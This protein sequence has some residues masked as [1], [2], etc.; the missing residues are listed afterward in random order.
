[1]LEPAMR[2]KP[3]MLDSGH[4]QPRDRGRTV[5]RTRPRAKLAVT[6]CRDQAYSPKPKV[7]SPKS[8]QWFL[9]L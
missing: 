2:W 6:F 3:A 4:E 8:G 1:M 7:D 5:P 9:G